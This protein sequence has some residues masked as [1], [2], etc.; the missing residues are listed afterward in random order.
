MVCSLLKSSMT[1]T[2]CKENSMSKGNDKGKHKLT[3]KEKQD[4]KKEKQKNKQQQAEDS[5]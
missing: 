5:E 3:I 4:R 2:F 1:L